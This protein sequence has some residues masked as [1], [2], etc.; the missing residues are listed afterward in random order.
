M[1]VSVQKS[2]FRQHWRIKLNCVKYPMEWIFLYFF[3]IFWPE[4]GRSKIPQRVQ[5]C[6]FTKTWLFMTQTLL[7]IIDIYEVINM[8]RTLLSPVKNDRRTNNRTKEYA[9]VQRWKKHLFN[10]APRINIVVVL[11]YKANKELF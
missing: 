9:H 5:R 6:Y 10:P 3:L 4:I 1:E 2:F 7:E 8:W 11:K